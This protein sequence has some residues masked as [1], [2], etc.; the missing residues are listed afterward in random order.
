MSSSGL[1]WYPALAS[2]N[3]S[4]PIDLI[5]QGNFAKVPLLIGTDEDEMSFFLCAK[6]ANMTTSEYEAAIKADFPK[7]FDEVLEMYPTSNYL[8]P[9][10]ALVDVWSDVYFKC[11]TR[12]VRSLSSVRL[13]TDLFLGC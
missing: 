11:P 13:R 10:D 3:I 5:S 7:L 6:N 1:R 12:S 8:R 4:Q 2:D 9:V